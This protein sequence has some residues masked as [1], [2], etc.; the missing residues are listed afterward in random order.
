MLRILCLVTAGT[1][2]DAAFASTYGIRGPCG[3]KPVRPGEGPEHLNVAT[4]ELQEVVNQP[5]I[6]TV[7]PR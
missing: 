1:A 3:W 4:I 6:K 5:G 2:L 7:T